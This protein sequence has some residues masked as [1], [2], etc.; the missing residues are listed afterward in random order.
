MNLT[1]LH[2]S[3]NDAFKAIGELGLRTKYLNSDYPK[4]IC[5]CVDDVKIVGSGDGV[6]WKSI[7]KFRRSQGDITNDDGN[8]KL[9]TETLIRVFG[10]L[11]YI[12]PPATMI[13]L[14]VSST[15]TLLFCS[16][17]WNVNEHFPPCAVSR[18]VRKPLH[19]DDSKSG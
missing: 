13:S 2:L 14:Q 8:L 19:I 3:N 12:L 7:E 4:A 15:D 9:P 17:S 11:R 16:I 10:F 18:R 5:V 1:K 6:V